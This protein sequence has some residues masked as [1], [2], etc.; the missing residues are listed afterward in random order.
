MIVKSTFATLS[1][2]H[3]F[4]EH[5]FKLEI[6]FHLAFYFLFATADWPCSPHMEVAAAAS[7][8]SCAAAAAS[9]QQTLTQLTASYGLVQDSFMASS[10]Y[11]SNFT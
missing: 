8:C 2:F 6:V 3:E 5:G 4:S 1:G 7:F 9:V 10:H 11:L